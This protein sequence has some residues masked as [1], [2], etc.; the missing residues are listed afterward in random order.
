MHL[1]SKA[2]D[3]Y[4]STPRNIRKAPTATS[5]EVL[6]ID[7]HTSTLLSSHLYIRI[8]ESVLSPL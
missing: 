1:P 3:N 8:Q 7:I 4:I 6:Y 2:A 5:Q